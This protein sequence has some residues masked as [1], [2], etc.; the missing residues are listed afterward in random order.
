[1]TASGHLTT[2]PL[3]SWQERA[4]T[5]ATT[6]RGFSRQCDDKNSHGQRSMEWKSALTKKHSTPSMT[7]AFSGSSKH[8]KHSTLEDFPALQ[9]LV[10]D[11]WIILDIP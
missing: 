9:V 3:L 11:I 1:M 5:K 10:Q 8:I 4:R 2:L 6:S 7:S